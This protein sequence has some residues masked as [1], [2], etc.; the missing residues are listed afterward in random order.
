MKKLM[1]VAA[2]A[3][4]AAYANAAAF[5]WATSASLTTD[6]SS[7]ATSSAA[8]NGGTF[9]LVYLGDDSANIDWSKAS[10][11]DTASPNFVTSTGSLV[12]HDDISATRTLSPTLGTSGYFVPKIVLL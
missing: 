1:I 11:V 6:G 2:V 12:I 8:M 10:V 4:C 7:V 5:S 9:A 3:L